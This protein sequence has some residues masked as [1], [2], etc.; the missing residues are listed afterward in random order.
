MCFSM[1]FLHVCI[2]RMTH[3]AWWFPAFLVRPIPCP[4]TS[5]IK[6]SSS[7]PTALLSPQTNRNWPQ[8]HSTSFPSRHLL[9][10]HCHPLGTVRATVRFRQHRSWRTSLYH[11]S[12]PSRTMVRL[13]QR[14]CTRDRRASSKGQTCAGDKS[15]SNELMHLLQNAFESNWSGQGSTNTS[16]R[17]MKKAGKESW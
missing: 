4:S 17:A 11:P 9:I 10:P 3:P 12:L 14:P 2:L 16:P 6:I 13:E 7:S 5:R 8:T 15:G 1:P